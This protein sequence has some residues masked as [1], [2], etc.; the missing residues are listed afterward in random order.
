[1][2][3]L[4]PVTLNGTWV[5]A[6]LMADVWVIGMLTD[7]RASALLMSSTK[8]ACNMSLTMPPSVKSRKRQETFGTKLST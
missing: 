5:A 1:M 8:R 7:P 2:T 4:P 6:V 3:P